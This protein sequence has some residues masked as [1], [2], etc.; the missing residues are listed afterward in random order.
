MQPKETNK[1]PRSW[2]PI[3]LAQSTRGL[4]ETCIFGVCMRKWLND[5]PFWSTFLEKEQ[6]VKVS[7]LIFLI[8]KCSKV[9]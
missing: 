1:N 6:E 9:N 8:Q 2:Y 5:S 3:T 7:L 4:G